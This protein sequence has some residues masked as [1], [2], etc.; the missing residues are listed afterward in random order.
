MR[1]ALAADERVVLLASSQRSDLA[2]APEGTDDGPTSPGTGL[3][4]LL[5]ARWGSAGA[6]TDPNPG[7]TAAL[8]SAADGLVTTRL[9]STR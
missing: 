6:G 4:A 5:A 2:P 9:G 1:T 3:R 8:R 7:L